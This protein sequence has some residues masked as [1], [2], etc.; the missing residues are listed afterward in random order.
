MGVTTTLLLNADARPVSFLP[1]SSISWQDAI[2]L[3]F[4]DTAEVLHSYDDWHVHSPSVTWAVPSVMM[5]RQQVLNVRQ[6]MA[7]DQSGPQRFLVFLRDM[8]VCQYCHRQFSRR[9]LTMDHVIP[10]VYGGRTRW[11]N[12]TTCCA[13]CNTKRGHD[14]RIQPR[15]R[16]ARPTYGQLIKNMR[17]LPILLPHPSWNHY[18][19]WDESLVRLADPRGS[20]IKNEYIDIGIKLFP[21]HSLVAMR[22][23][24]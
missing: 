17:R 20:Q 4:L 14:T 7:H 5:M 3:M 16:P 13:Q 6:W 9:Q 11:E 12:I 23:S 24:I 2:R 19:G 10:R 18:L 8:F 15:T 22:N 1:L 21:N